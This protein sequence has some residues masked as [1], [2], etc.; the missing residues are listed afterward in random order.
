MNAH[1]FLSQI[2]KID[3]IIANKL[4]E[5]K[6]WSDVARSLGGISSGERVQTSSNFGR[7]PDAVCRYVDLEREIEDL[8]RE[9]AAI[10][11]RIEQLPSDEYKIIYA[12]YVE[13]A[14]IKEVAYRLGKSYDSI[15]K[16]K[17]K[18]LRMVQGLNDSAEEGQT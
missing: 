6:R 18:A 13:G 9:R 8:K 10:I 5:V 15:K 11:R 4:R 2:I 12:I 3:A 14:S 16:R 7:V 17:K 1:E